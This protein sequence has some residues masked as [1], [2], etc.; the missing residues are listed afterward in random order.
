M[1]TVVAPVAGFQG[2]SYPTAG[3]VDVD[4][5]GASL[6]VVILYANNSWAG[7]TPSVTYKGAPMEMVDTYTNEVTAGFGDLSVYT[8]ENPPAGVGTVAYSQSTGNY[9]AERVLLA[10][11][12]VGDGAS[13]TASLGVSRP[14]ADGPPMQWPHTLAGI[15]EGNYIVDATYGYWLTNMPTP[16]RGTVIAE[17]TS[18]PAVKFRAVGLV[19]T[20]SSETITW[21]IDP[22]NDATGFILA[23]GADA[24]VPKEPSVMYIKGNDG[25]PV[26]AIINFNV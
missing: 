23:I 18:S 19:A 2:G 12:V 22:F 11:P 14:R 17:F 15:S 13:L 24:A 21:T 5:T 20:G 10:L 6:L 7:G 26:Q 3:S 25:S 1:A 16:D 9:N 4:T 8:L